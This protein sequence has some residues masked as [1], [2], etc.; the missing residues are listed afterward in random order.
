MNRARRERK[1]DGESTDASRNMVTC[2]FIHSL[3]FFPPSAIIPYA[4]RGFRCSI[5]VPLVLVRPVL[6][7]FV[8]DLPVCLAIV[9][10][11]VEN[12]NPTSTETKTPY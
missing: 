6:W 9:S 3:L 11:L 1:C 10:V 4:L 5:V 12:M 8:C 2:F 7:I